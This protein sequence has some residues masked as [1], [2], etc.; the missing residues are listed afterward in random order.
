[1]TPEQQQIAILE[2]C[3]WIFERKERVEHMSNALTWHIT[4]P[5]G[6]TRNHWSETKFYRNE[7]P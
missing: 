6:E 7:S 2:A 4:N 1:M 5:Q 3:G